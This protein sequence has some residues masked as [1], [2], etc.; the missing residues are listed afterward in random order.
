M[1]TAPPTIS[2]HKGS[3]GLLSLLDPLTF[4]FVEGSRDKTNEE[5]KDGRAIFERPIDRDPHAK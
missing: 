5:I 2:I 4:T 3:L 1:T